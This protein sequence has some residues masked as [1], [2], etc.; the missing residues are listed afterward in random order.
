MTRQSPLLEIAHLSVTFPLHGVVEAVSDVSFTLPRGRVVCL[1]GESG[2]G[3]SVTCHRNINRIDARR[4]AI[5]LLEMV[6]IPS[7]ARCD[8]GGDIGASAATG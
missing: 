2:S 8:E 3:K 1:L 7:P 5:E 6:Q 4:R